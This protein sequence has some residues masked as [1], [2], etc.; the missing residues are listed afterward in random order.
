MGPIESLLEEAGRMNVLTG[1]MWHLLSGSVHPISEVNPATVQFRSVNS[2]PEKEGY[3]VLK[4]AG[5]RV[6]RRDARTA[7]SRARQQ[8]G[9]GELNWKVKLEAAW[10]WLVLSALKKPP[11]SESTK[12]PHSPPPPPP[13]PSVQALMMLPSLVIKCLQED[14]QAQR[15]PPPLH[16]PYSFL[17]PMREGGERGKRK[18]GGGRREKENHVKHDGIV[19]LVSII[20]TPSFQ[21]VRTATALEGAKK[22]RRKGGMEATLGGSQ[23]KVYRFPQNTTYPETLIKIPPTPEWTASPHTPRHLSCR[24]ISSAAG[25]AGKSFLKASAADKKALDQSGG[26]LFAAEAFRKALLA[27]EERGESVDEHPPKIRPG[28]FFGGKKT[29]RQSLLQGNTVALNLQWNKRKMGHAEAENGAHGG[30]NRRWWSL[31]PETADHRKAHPTDNQLLAVC[32]LLQGGKWLG[33]RASCGRFITK[34]GNT[35]RICREW[36]LLSLPLPPLP[37]HN[38]HC[39]LG[40]MMLPSWHQGAHAHL[41]GGRKKRGLNLFPKALEGRTRSNGWKPIRERSNLELRRNFLTGGTINQWNPLP[42]EVVNAATLGGFLRRQGVGLE[43]LQDSFQL[44]SSILNGTFPTKLHDW[45]RQNH[46]PIKDGMPNLSYGLFR[47][48]TETGITSGVAEVT[49]TL[50]MRP[51]LLYILFLECR[52]FSSATTADVIEEAGLRHSA[53]RKDTTMTE[54]GA[55]SRELWKR[56][57]KEERGGG[58]GGRRRGG[59]GE[60]GGGEEREGGEEGG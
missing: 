52:N 54:E 13:T 4:R 58:G 49:V 9:Q 8:T 2:A 3:S 41:Q 21:R 5:E 37:L 14:H 50:A 34:L 11:S 43:D 7:L 42:P 25:K 20:R 23:P 6:K 53:H 60:G 57:K 56:R 16:K 18:R 38:P 55:N 22:E 10:V 45:F 28:A 15:A 35:I 31:Q 1:R 17:A 27:A 40:L 36:A 51:F 39:L 33:G 46:S 47:V 30:G 26:L 59:G 32:S 12:V 29:I 19:A 44:R 48:G 24:P